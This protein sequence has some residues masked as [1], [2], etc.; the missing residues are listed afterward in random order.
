LVVQQ[1]VTPFKEAEELKDRFLGLVAHELRT[2]LTTI[3][4]YASSLLMERTRDQGTSL[5]TWQQ[6]A[7]AE[8]DLSA[9]LLTRLT[10]DLPLV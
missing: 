5:V 8:I 1:D 10:N 4:G 7:V 6:E 9:D 3:K 2:P